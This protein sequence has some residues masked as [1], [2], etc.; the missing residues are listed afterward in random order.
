MRR[1]VGFTHKCTRTNVALERF[2]AAIR[3]RPMMLL[4]IPLCR[5]LLAANGARK[6]LVCH[7]VRRH[8]RFYTRRQVCGAADWTV[9]RLA[10]RKHIFVGVGKSDVSGERVSVR[11]TLA[12]IRTWFRLVFVRLLM[13]FELRFCLENL[14]AIAHK[15]FLLRFLVQMNARP[16][17]QHVGIPPESL[18]TMGTFNGHRTG[19]NAF[20]FHQPLSLHESLRTESTTMHPDIQMVLEMKGKG[21]PAVEGFLAQR[22]LRRMHLEVF[23][24][25][26]Q[27]PELLVALR[28]HVSSLDFQSQRGKLRS[29]GSRRLQQQP[30]HLHFDGSSCADEHSIHLV[31][32]QHRGRC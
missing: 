17:V 27:R 29:R 8:V 2:R 22:A 21:V 6:F 26:F 18:V 11:E 30:I 32:H 31:L 3:M 10:F 9:D 23:V 12:T 13:P 5:E 15:I 19:V 7:R 4:Q 25:E 16:M 28:A 1:V 20:M 14:A 24:E